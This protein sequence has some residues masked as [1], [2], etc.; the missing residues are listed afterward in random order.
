MRTAGCQTDWFERSLGD[1]FVAGGP[2]NEPPTNANI[3]EGLSPVPCSNADQGVVQNGIPWIC[4]H[5]NTLI[6]AAYCAPKPSLR[7]CMVTAP[8]GHASKYGNV[9]Q[10]R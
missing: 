2:Y 9:S 5:E 8:T 4:A 1:R 6:I 10:P 3:S 7:G